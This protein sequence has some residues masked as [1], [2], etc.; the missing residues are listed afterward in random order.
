ML[1]RSYGYGGWGR[2]GPWG[3]GGYGRGCGGPGGWHGGWHGGPHRARHGWYTDGAFS[4]DDNEDFEPWRRR[5]GG[6]EGMFFGLRAI[7]DRLETTPG[8][9]KAI[10]AAFDDLRGKGRAVKEDARGLRSDLA[11]AF[12]GES[13][14]AETLG[15]IASRT[16]GAIDSARDAAIGAV[17]KVHD[18]LDERQRAIVAELLESGPGFGRWRGRGGPYRAARG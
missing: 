1:R 10:R 15:T 5:G 12:R 6:P 2:G 3:Y 8:Q 7:L 16:T 9:E 18:A 13:L 4:D 14:D 11:S 17:L